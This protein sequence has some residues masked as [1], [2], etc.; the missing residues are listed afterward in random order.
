MSATDPN[1]SPWRKPP[2]RRLLEETSAFATVVELVNSRGVITERSG[3]RVIRLARGL[4]EH[5]DIHALSITDNPGGNAVLSADTLGTDLISRGQEV[6]I[7]LSCKDWNRNALQSHA[8]KLAS[9]GFRNV[10][11]LSGDYPTS[12]YGGEAA[13]VFDTDSVGLLQMMSDMNSGLESRT[14]KGRKLRMQRTRFFTGAVVNNFKRLENEVMPQY[15]KL[16]KKIEAGAAFIIEQIGYNARKQDELLRYLALK[17]LR[18]PVLAN[19]Y[20]LSRPAARYFHS[21]RIPGVTVTGDLLAR[22]EKEAA[23]ADKGKVFFLELA[24]KQC[25]VARGLGYRGVYLGGHLQLEDYDRVLR[26]CQ[27][28]A[29]DD[30]KQFAPELNYDLEDEFYFFE[31]DSQSGL[32]TDEISRTYLAS[33]E[34]T[35]LS[36]LRRRTALSY[37]ANRQ[38]HQRVFVPGSTGFRLGRALSEAAQR[39]GGR[40]Q[41]GLHAIEQAIKIPAF[42]CRD[43]GDC[44]L[45]DIAYLCPESQ[46]V[47]NQRNGPCG[48]THDGQCEIGDKE[49]IWARAYDRLKAFGEEEQMLAGPAVYRDG[50]LKGTSAWI[51]TFLGR[52]HHGQQRSAAEE[53]EEERTDARERNSG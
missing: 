22:V 5:P 39:A 40:L 2:L 26:L 15:F 1:F 13:G 33:K 48:G 43:C 52:D 27:S 50:A 8:W 4:A 9:E 28:F 53:T 21:G 20:V 38:V 36:S 42:D 51:N 46:C 12:G 49:C 24:A 37:R 23:S 7:H 3:S 11:A 35:A 44:S 17:N 6:I 16:A 32:N 45:P 30:W 10:L 18:V 31:P 34:G 19:V 14:P 47:K 41:R 29:E 25:A